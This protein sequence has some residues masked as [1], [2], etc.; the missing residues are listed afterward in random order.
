MHAAFRAPS[1]S[2]WRAVGRTPWSGCPL[3]PDTHVP[4]PDQRYRRLPWREQ[5]EGG[6][7]C[8]PGGSAYQRCFAEYSRYVWQ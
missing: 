8:E 1:M 5:A 3:G 4:L 7:G 6:V 2:A